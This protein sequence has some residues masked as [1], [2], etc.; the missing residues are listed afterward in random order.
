M[1]SSKHLKCIGP[2]PANELFRTSAAGSPS[3][4]T[5]WG[6]VMQLPPSLLFNFLIIALVAKSRTTI[7]NWFCLASTTSR[8]RLEAQDG[9]EGHPSPIYS[10]SNA[11]PGGRL[12]LRP[13]ASFLRDVH[14]LC[15]ARTR[16]AHG[17]DRL[18]RLKK[19]LMQIQRTQT[20]ATGL[21]MRSNL[22]LKGVNW[23]IEQMSKS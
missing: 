15:K 21:G 17:A 11:P 3:W 20:V 2:T 8:S 18:C 4:A 19:G 5:T 12:L 7:S 6:R 9:L 1:A 23:S 14:Q 22:Q 13:N 16:N 10:S